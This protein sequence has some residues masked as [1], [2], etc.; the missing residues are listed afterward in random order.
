MSTTYYTSDHEWLAIEDTV[1]TLGI[2]DHAQDALGEIVFVESP[3]IGAA[4]IKGEAIAVVE[5][6]KAASD[7]YA[8]INGEVIEV[9]TLLEDSP[10]MVNES[11]ETEGWFIKIR[12]EESFETD[13]YMSK[14]EYLASIAD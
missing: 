8:P 4:C 3:D 10:E 7:I 12:L 9:N 5:S 2:T 1:A 14:E 11:P 13:S 6:V